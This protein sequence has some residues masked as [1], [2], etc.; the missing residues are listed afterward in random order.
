M[1]L[2]PEARSKQKLRGPTSTN[3]K[4]KLTLNPGEATYAEHEVHTLIISI[5]R[6][7]SSGF[8]PLWCDGKQ[9]FALQFSVSRGKNALFSLNSQSVNSQHSREVT[10]ACYPGEETLS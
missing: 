2:Y 6:A 5:N 9:L 8:A 1:G 3:V 7:T 4:M 10:R